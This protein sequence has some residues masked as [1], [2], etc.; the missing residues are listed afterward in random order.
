[1]T[2]VSGISG[3]GD[4]AAAPGLED[5]A[6]ADDAET[7]GREDHRERHLGGHR[8]RLRVGAKA[9][10]RNALFVPAAAMEPSVAAGAALYPDESV[11]LYRKLGLV[12]NS[13][14]SCPPAGGDEE[15]PTRPRVKS[16][17]PVGFVVTIVPFSV[18]VPPTSD[19]FWMPA[20]SSATYRVSLPET[21]F[22]RSKK[23]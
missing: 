23:A 4:L 6:E 7:R 2:I 1:M 13:V 8:R 12:E 9:T 3:G 15:N 20:A 17:A 21:L 18:Q 19:H 10:P 22:V 14:T 16:L 5:Q 11:T